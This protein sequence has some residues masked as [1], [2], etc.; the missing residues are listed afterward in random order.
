MA[1]QGI[2]PFSRVLLD[3][4]DCTDSVQPHGKG[5]KETGQDSVWEVYKVV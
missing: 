3:E 1:F 4:L 2:Q 5:V